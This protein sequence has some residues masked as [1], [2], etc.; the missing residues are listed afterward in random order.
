M[1][2]VS[3]ALDKPRALTYLWTDARTICQRLG[4]ISLVDFLTKLGQTTPDVL[5]TA[6]FIG[7]SNED[8]KLTG[9]KLDDLIQGFINGG[10]QLSTLVNAVLE[11]MTEDG[12]L[13]AEKKVTQDPT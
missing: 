6:L 4:G 10:G 1:S 5:H 12:L 8:P 13:Y 11:A 3:L 9:K 7:L 2:T